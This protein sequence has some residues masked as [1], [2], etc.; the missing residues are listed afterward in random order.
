MGLFSATPADGAVWI[1]GG[2][3]G[4][5]AEAAK[6]LADQGFCVFVSAR[7]REDIEALARV[8]NGPGEIRSLP[9]DVTDKQACQ[10]AV[11]EIGRMGFEIAIAIFSAG[12]YQPMKGSELI[13]ET[14]EKTFIVNFNGVV[15]C[16]V[17]AVERMKK[18]GKG[19]IAVISSVSGYGG[20]RMA[21][22][23]G[24][25]KAALINMCESLKFDFDPMNIKIQLVNPGFIDTPMTA[26]NKFPMPFL[27]PVDK[28]ADYM[29]SCL[30]KDMFEITFPRRFTYL[31]KFVN[32]LPY[33]L[34]FW[35]VGKGTSGG[36]KQ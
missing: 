30:K 18:A 15:N 34:Y 6:R 1:T 14:F 36:R 4:I 2:S 32:I 3:S 22:A 29:V 25:S 16:L 12:T 10:H 8:Y 23:Y 5:G 24:A 7:S 33:Q 21:S 31:L 17:P 13:L 28:A 11:D 20:L 19:Q 27:M 9:L 35:I 26:T